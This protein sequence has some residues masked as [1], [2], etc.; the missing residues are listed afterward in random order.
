MFEPTAATRVAVEMLTLWMESG[1]QAREDAARHI[2]RVTARAD[3]LPDAQATMR[4]MGGLLNLSML[5][6]LLELAAER[7]GRDDADR[8]E[9]EA[10]RWLRGFSA[11]LAE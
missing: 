4:A 6:L 9:A 8:V 3:G 11:R 7:I 10:G 2:Y 1:E 5:L